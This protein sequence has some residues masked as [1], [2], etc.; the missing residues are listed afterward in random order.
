MELA[1][2][3]GEELAWGRFLLGPASVC[4]RGG[5]SARSSS[6]TLSRL[7]AGGTGVGRSTR[8]A[9]GFVDASAARPR[10]AEQ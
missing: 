4:G 7:G 3:E 5:I 6:T 10:L 9:G 1:E 2:G 8:L